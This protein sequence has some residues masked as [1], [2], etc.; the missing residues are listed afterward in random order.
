MKTDVKTWKT[1]DQVL[2][3][4]TRPER[5]LQYGEGNFLR[6]FADWQI[7]ILNERTSFNGNVV[8]VQPRNREGAQGALINAQRG[9]YTTVLRGLEGGRPVEEFRAIR[10]LSRCINPYTQ[11]Y[12]YIACAENPELRFVFSNT[13]EAGISYREGEELRD[14]PQLSFPGKLS[15]FLHR[16]YEYFRGDPSKALVVI[17]C[18]L[19]ERNGDTLRRV[20]ERHAAA[21][22]LGEDFARWCGACVF[23]NTLVDRIISGFPAEEAEALWDRLG[24]QDRLLTAGESFHLWVIETPDTAPGV[25]PWDCRRELPL[26]E[27]GLKVVWTGNLDLYRTRKV[28]ILNGAHSSTA[29][30]AYLYGLDT[31]DQCVADP[32][33][34]RFIRQ[35]IFDEI[36]PSIEPD[37][38]PRTAEGISPEELTRFA[39]ETLERFA[40]PSLKHQLLSI[41]LNSVS[42]FKARVLPSILSYHKK[43]GRAPKALCCSLAALIAF[44]RGAI[45]DGEMEGR[46]TKDGVESRY[47]IRDD[48]EIL[49][50]FAELWAAPDHVHEVLSCRELWGEDLGL[51]PALEDAVRAALKTI[52]HEGVG[53]ALAQAAGGPDTRAAGALC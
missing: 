22:R 18:E 42:K 9:L 3:P 28:R 13:T 49:R 43:Y 11:F 26:E 4:V 30:A 53:A 32:L 21:W 41:S 19:I 47:P 50:R 7:D 38:G 25:P 33:V 44:Y 48:G 2:Q 16:R 23:C 20:V 24:Y 39:R 45:T 37:T 10:S 34:Y 46:R 35:A 5:I 15:A 27:A 6:G 31:V 36:I 17:P 29:L 14:R 12:E 40:N 51:Y 52:L 1:I 8:A